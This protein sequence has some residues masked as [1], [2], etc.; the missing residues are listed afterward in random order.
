[1]VEMTDYAPGTPS[2]VDVSTPDMEA[3]KAFYGGLFGWETMTYPDMDL[4]GYT[5]FTLNGKLVCGAAPTMSPDQQPAWGTYICVADADATTQAIRH[6]GGQV[7]MEPMGVMGLGRMALFIDPTGAFFGIWQPGQHKGAQL[8]NEPG[9]FVW[10]E[11]DTRDMDTAKTFYTKVFPWAAKTNGEGVN[12][13]TEWQL[14]G[15]SI[16]GG[17][18]I[19]DQFPPNVPPNWL[20]YFAVGDCDAIVARAHEL[21]GTVIMPGMDTEQG[22]FAVLS[23]SQGAVFAVIQSKE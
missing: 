16:A 15:R 20:T 13:Y 10:N 3:T 22:R 17:M 7:V 5:N 6:N 19:N 11:L 4:G 12:A 1:M 9:A 23:D 2:W 14:G 21:G 18:V 8:V